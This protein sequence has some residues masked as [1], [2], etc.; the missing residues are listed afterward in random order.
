MRHVIWDP[1][2]WPGSPCRTISQSE[3]ASDTVPIHSSIRVYFAKATG[4][5]HRSLLEY[6]DHYAARDVSPSTRVRAQLVHGRIPTG[7]VTE[8]PSST[9]SSKG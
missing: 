6:L 4:G 5:A 9:F 3:S 1:R 2:S 8:H 7:A